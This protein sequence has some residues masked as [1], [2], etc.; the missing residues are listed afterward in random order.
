MALK[1]FY[2]SQSDVPEALRS[3]YA[4]REGRWVLD[5]GAED[6]WGL[7][8]VAGLKRALSEER[9]GRKEAEAKLSTAT[10]ELDEARAGAGKANGKSAEELRA[11]IAR[12]LGE[13][14]AQEIKL[15]EE[16]AAKLQAQCERLLIDSE[17]GR[18]LS[19]PGLKG[20]LELL[21]GPIRSRV[22]TETT[23]DGQVRVKVLDQKGQPM[24]ATRGSS[25]EEATLEDLV[26]SMRD[27]QRYQRAFDG[28]PATGGRNLNG[29][30]GP[31]SGGASRTFDQSLSPSA[32]LKSHYEGQA[33]TS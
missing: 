17:A 8:D 10:S 28:T 13:R 4:E 27:D 16:R 22:Q 23:D 14:H 26:R 19:S 31:G 18:L 6:G 21:I 2:A 1:P 9:K 3:H 25:V 29:A 30:G 20:D 15:R 24:Y 33:V 32:K 12:E 7:E 5:V 11:T